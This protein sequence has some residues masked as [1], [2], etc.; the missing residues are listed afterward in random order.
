MKNRFI[1]I[2]LCMC[3]ASCA[4][5]QSKEYDF[6]KHKKTLK[7]GYS[8]Q[9]MENEF[10]GKQD[11]KMAFD[12]SQVK[13]IFLHKKAIAGKVKFGIDWG[14][15]VEYAYFDAEDGLDGYTGVTGYTGTGNSYYE[16]EDEA[17]GLN[18]KG[19]HQLDYGLKVGPSITYN[20][21]GN[22]R[23]CAYF[24]CTPSLSMQ[25]LNGDYGYGFVPFFDTGL[26]IS[27]RWIGLGAEIRKG[28]GKYNSIA[29]LMDEGEDEDY[30]FDFPKS[31]YGTSA[32]RF[33]LVFRL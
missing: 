11:A 3:V 1:A 17:E 28:V 20:P 30:H 4:F 26:E 22:L 5:A 7:L 12:L 19:I 32:L 10:G 15:N 8:I 24:H 29:E 25:I 16:P 18:I 21:V 6:W 23:L 13:T 14:F 9:S 31:K 27:Y 2:L 33:Y